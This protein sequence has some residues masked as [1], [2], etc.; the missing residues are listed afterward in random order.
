METGNA[1]HSDTY[2]VQRTIGANG[3]AIFQVSHLANYR[4]NATGAQTSSAAADEAR[5][6]TE[7]LAFGQSRL[8]R[9]EVTE[10]ADDHKK[11]FGRVALHEGEEGCV[12]G[13]GDLKLVGVL[14]EEENTIV[15]ELADDQTQDLAEIATGDELLECLFAR[16]V[17]LLVNGH[18]VLRARKMLMLEGVEGSLEMH[19]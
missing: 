6:C 17:R 14:T 9:K 4:S 16:L 12:E 18:V 5:K 15:D 11:L 10:D 3:A 19:D 2:V 13:V 1:A 8:E 7:E